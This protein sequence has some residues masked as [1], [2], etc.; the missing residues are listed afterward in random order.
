MPILYSCHPRSRKHI[1]G[2]GFKLDTRVIHHEPLAFMTTK[3]CGVR[4][5]KK[6]QPARIGKACP[7]KIGR[8]GKRKLFLRNLLSHLAL[9]FK[10][11]KKQ[12]DEIF[13]NNQSSHK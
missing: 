6:A 1:E 12:A 9:R 10:I 11:S 8:K 5:S 7:K 3:L 13:I 2:S 4:Y